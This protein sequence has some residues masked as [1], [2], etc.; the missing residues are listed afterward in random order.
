MLKQSEIKRLKKNG[1]SIRAISRAL[2]TS[3]KT[4]RKYLEKEF[5]EEQ[6]RDEGPLWAKS[7]NWNSIN[8]DFQNGTPLIIL[9]EEKYESREVPVKYPAFWKQFSK[10]YPSTP[11]TM[12]RQ[13]EP[14]SRAE[15]DYCDGI[16]IVNPYTGEIQKTHFFMGVL[17]R[18]RYTYGEFS[19]SQKS[20][21]FLN[22]HVRM[23]E[24][25]GGVPHTL[26]PDNLKS[27]VSKAHRYD[28]DINPAYARLGEHYNFSPT[29]A[30]VR[31]PKDKAIVERNI[32]IFQKW[33]YAR[34]R[35]RTF[36]SLV[37][38]NNCL[39]EALEI[40]NNRVHRIFKKSRKEMFEEEKDFLMSLPEERYQVRSHKKATL[41][42]DCH[43]Q[44]EYNYYSA[45]WK[46][47]GKKLD[48]WATDTQVE[49]FYKGESVAIHPRK[50]N[51]G[52]FV[53]KRSHYP[54]QHQ[55]YLEI[56]P[57]FLRE[58]SKKMGNN[59]YTLINKLMSVKHPLRYLRRCQGILA[60]EKKFEVI[61]IEKACEIALRFEKFHIGFLENILKNNSHKIKSNDH[62]IPRGQNPNLRGLS[63]F[64]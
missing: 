53:T 56:T 32:Q 60:L 15:I 19:F 4:V 39:R 16:D 21:D 63:Y 6:I 45:P 18:S 57:S 14:G 52:K 34:N 42:N 47:R 40:F 58:K 48:V 46:L 64:Q 3:R 54:P 8:S 43:L 20:E 30:R 41:H 61:D 11:P 26:A 10:R 22:S 59:T 44:F 5:L 51:R 13:W 27:A 28:P 36:T 50:K 38:L 2:K 35:K 1:L 55:A 49:I 37:E 17:C 7:L 12:V 31:A 25:F 23:F 9:W 29:P 24:Y 33:F 62:S